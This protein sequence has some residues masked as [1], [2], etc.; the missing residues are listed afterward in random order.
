VP[1]RN[2]T[3]GVT[4]FLGLGTNLGDRV[5]NI[6][7]A[8]SRLQHLSCISS[9]QSSSLYLSSPLGYSAQPDFINCALKIDVRCGA[10]QLLA[11]VLEIEESLGRV[12]DRNNQNAARIIDIDLLLFGD[13]SISSASL[14]IPHARLCERLFV[15]EPLLELHAD[16]EIPDCGSLSALRQ[17]GFSDGLFEQQILHKLA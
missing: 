9:I 14:T 12:R 4:S 16:L 3:K 1:I 2:E 7:D 6:I 17:K 11:Q 13:H 5:Q 15:I 8:R 10:D